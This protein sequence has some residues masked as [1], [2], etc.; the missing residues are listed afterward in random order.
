MIVSGSDAFFP[1]TLV[2]RSSLMDEGRTFQATD[3]LYAVWF[4]DGTIYWIEAVDDLP[5]QTP[6]RSKGSGTR[7]VRKC[8]RFRDA[9][10][11]SS[12]TRS[13]FLRTATDT[14]FS[15]GRPGIEELADRAL[16]D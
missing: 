14:E 6:R 3:T 7:D 5:F 4:P 1:E 2:E 9:L 13:K 16:G 10:T 15:Q 11:Y 8:G 12:G